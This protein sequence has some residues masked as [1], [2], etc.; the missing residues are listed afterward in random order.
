LATDGR[1][2][3]ISPLAQRRYAAIL[4][5]A[6]TCLERALDQRDLDT[7]GKI[8]HKLVGSAPMFGHGRLGEIAADIQK[9][10][11]AGETAQLD[12]YRQKIIDY[13]EN[14]RRSA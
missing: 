1:Q 11:R 8:A 2:F 9:L 5:D 14:A 4:A 7:A 6:L 12:L 3:Q 13:A 10:A